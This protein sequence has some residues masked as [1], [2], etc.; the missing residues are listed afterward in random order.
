VLAGA[1]I[2]ILRSS[3]LSEEQSRAIVTQEI[4]KN[5]ILYVEW[6][7]DISS[8]ATAGYFLLDMEVLIY[9]ISSRYMGFFGKY[10]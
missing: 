9:R 3:A 10:A 5:F 4:T 8:V 6:Y 2:A 1:F 7:R